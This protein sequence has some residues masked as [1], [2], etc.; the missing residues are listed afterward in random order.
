MMNPI[1]LVGS[2]EFIVSNTL[3]CG[4][5]GWNQAIVQLKTEKVQNQK[6]L[7]QELF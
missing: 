3:S 5:K 1:F 2:C 6:L 4:A 7:K